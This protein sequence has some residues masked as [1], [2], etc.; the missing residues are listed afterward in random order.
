ME[1][2]RKSDE[3]EGSGER[4]CKGKTKISPTPLPFIV[5]LQRP[6]ATQLL[7]ET[8]ILYLN[9]LDHQYM[10]TKEGEHI[11][12]PVKHSSLQVQTNVRN[13]IKIIYFGKILKTMKIHSVTKCPQ[14]GSNYSKDNLI[15]RDLEL[16]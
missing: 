11:E 7:G 2:E 12:H 6:P 15:V 14:Q 4:F 3:G 13:Q 8:C 9:H 16:T 1:K 10:P 5:T